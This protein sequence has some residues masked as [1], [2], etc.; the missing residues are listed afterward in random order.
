[1]VVA[2]VVERAGSLA[3][4]P[5]IS[6]LSVTNGEAYSVGFPVTLGKALVVRGGGVV[7]TSSGFEVN[8]TLD[9]TSPRLK[10]G[11]TVLGIWAK[12]TDVVFGDGV[13]PS[14]GPLV[15]SVLTDGEESV[16]TANLSSG[17][18]FGIVVV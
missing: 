17:K 7:P 18:W 2:V 14:T 8:L 11:S 10:V 15:V 6:G 16:T 1:M 13:S 5:R 12:V 3:V 4:L 9:V